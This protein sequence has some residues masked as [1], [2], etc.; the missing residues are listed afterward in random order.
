MM[1]MGVM[2]ILMYVLI[3]MVEKQEIEAVKEN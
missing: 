3:T 2:F 1:L